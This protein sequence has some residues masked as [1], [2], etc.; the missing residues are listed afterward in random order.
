MNEKTP[1]IPNQWVQEPSS[2]E[3]DLRELMVVL[4]RQKLLI[5]L[6]AGVFAVGGIFY[7]LLAP[8]QWSAKAVITEP[9]PEDLQPMQ[10]VARSAAALGLTGFPDGKGLYQEFVQEFN[11]YKNR[12]AYLKTSPLFANE[13]TTKA[14]DEK[15][16]RRWLRDW[17]KLVVAQPVDKKGETLDIEIAFAAPTNDDSLAMLKGY[18]DYIVTLQQQQ[19]MRRLGEQRTLQLEEMGTRYTVM[20]EEAK[21]TLQQEISE[22]AL[23]NSVAKAAGVS[24]PLER[25]GITQDRFSIALGS[26]G[27]EEKMTLLKSV[28]LAFYQPGLQQLQAQMDRLKRVSLEGI[29]FRPFSYLD[30]PEEPL[31]RDKPKRPL[32]VVLATLLGGMLGVGVVLVR[33]A[34]RRPEQV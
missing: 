32:V 9:K 15:A 26:K 13:V 1:V 24:T 30:A 25:I 21:R 31:S 28:D 14:L 6:I 17:G 34:F 16:Q 3:I 29:S 4:W 12:S 23:A 11:S 19:L 10:K 33:H 2:E 22:I 20:K 18:V 27:L 7:A 8:Q 5:V